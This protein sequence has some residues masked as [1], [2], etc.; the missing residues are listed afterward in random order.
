MDVEQESKVILITGAAGFMY[1]CFCCERNLATHSFFVFLGLVL[2][3]SL[4]A[5][6]RRTPIM[7]LSDLI[8][9]IIV[10]H[11]RILQ[12]PGSSPTLPL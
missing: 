11:S 8:S 5:L 1:V 7:R 9:W 12:R 2:H 4:I 6:S 3:M 10:H